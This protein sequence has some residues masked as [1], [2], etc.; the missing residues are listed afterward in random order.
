MRTPLALALSLALPLSAATLASAARAQECGMPLRFYEDAP[1]VADID[2]APVRDALEAG[3]YEEAARL[4]RARLDATTLEQRA[5]A[6]TLRPGRKFNEEEVRVALAAAVIRTGGA[7]GLAAPVSAKLS[8][9]KAKAAQARNLE[10]ARALLQQ[11]LSR[12]SGDPV[13]ATLLGEAHLALGDVDFAGQVLED[14]AEADLIVSPEGWSALAR[15][16]EA[17]GKS[18]EAAAAR[19]RCEDAA[20]DG[21]V[22]Q[23]TPAV[24]RS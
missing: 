9:K 10:N 17:A 19:K 15:A 20:R 22:C 6:F 13:I 23:P 11:E 3:R 16:R 12:Q 4:A 1:R 2:A 8:Q 7:E 24:A 18:E 5:A 21:A 14:L